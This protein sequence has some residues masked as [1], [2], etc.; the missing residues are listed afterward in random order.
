MSVKLLS[1]AKWC[2]T[3]VTEPVVHWWKPLHLRYY[4]ST[5]TFPE[6]NHKQR[7]ARLLTQQTHSS[8]CEVA[9]SFFR[10]LLALRINGYYGRK[11]KEKNRWLQ[12]MKVGTETEVR[13]ENAPAITVYATGAAKDKQSE[14][15]AN[16]VPLH[17]IE[18]EVKSVHDK[19]LVQM[20][21]CFV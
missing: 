11:N 4:V 19:T 18:Q 3:M 9:Y 15:L 14:N 2:N 10:S 7:R 20:L 13:S 16:L 21:P 8:V 6:K 12:T 5:A 1:I 17:N